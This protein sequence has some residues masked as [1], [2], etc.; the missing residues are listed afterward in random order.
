MSGC[1]TKGP[2]ELGT[3]RW[4]Q[5]RIMLRTSRKGLKKNGAGEWGRTTDLLITNQLL[6]H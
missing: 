6:Y 2:L 4:H 5:V 3:K 1:W